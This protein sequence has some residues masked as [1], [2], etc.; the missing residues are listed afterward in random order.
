VCFAGRSRLFPQRPHLLRC[1]SGG[2]LLRRKTHPYPCECKQAQHQASMPFIQPGIRCPLVAGSRNFH[3]KVTA[4]SQNYVHMNDANGIY[5]LSPM[6]DSSDQT[7][8]RWTAIHGRLRRKKRVPKFDHW[9][10]R[11]HEVLRDCRPAARSLPQLMNQ[12]D[13]QLATSSKRMNDFWGNLYHQLRSI[14]SLDEGR[15][16]SGARRRSTT[17]SF[18]SIPSA[19]RRMA[20]WGLICLKITY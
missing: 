18:R 2:K 3:R 15:A 9:V 19:M 4:R 16:L 13:Y 17:R 8:G 14:W 12:S 7:Q 1:L 10:R 11:R 6:R 5:D 20:L